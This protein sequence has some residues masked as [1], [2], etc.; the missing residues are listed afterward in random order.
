MHKSDAIDAVT[1]SIATSTIAVATM[2]IAITII[3]MFCCCEG[4][5]WEVNL[6]QGG[7]EGTYCSGLGK[8]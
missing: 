2:V 1:E 3:V 7:R 8:R 5:C 4:R 6:G